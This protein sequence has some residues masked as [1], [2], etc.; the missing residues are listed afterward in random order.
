MTITTARPTTTVTTKAPPVPALPKPVTLAAAVDQLNQFTSADDIAFHLTAHG[1]N[2]RQR[3]PGSCP[4]ARYLKG[5]TTRSYFLGV[6]TQ[7][8]VMAIRRDGFRLHPEE[9][10]LSPAAREFVIKFDRGEY[11]WLTK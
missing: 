9:H 2:G 8:L 5:N 6:G 10:K 3:Y 4:I 1:I 7:G 11:P